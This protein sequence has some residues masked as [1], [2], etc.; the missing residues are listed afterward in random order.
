MSKEGVPAETIIERM[1]DSDTV[2]RFT[3]AQLANLREQGVSDQVID[4]MQQ[5]YLDAVSQDQSLEDWDY[6]TVGADG[7]FVFDRDGHR[8]FRDGREGHEGRQGHDGHEGER[9]RE[10]GES[11]GGGGFAGHGG[12][13][14]GGGGLG[15]G[16]GGHGGR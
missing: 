16:G 5:T 2:Y 7:F 9:G 10:G 15:G 3:A 13:G 6:W 12:G 1:R 4:Y 14:H 11:Q 8:G